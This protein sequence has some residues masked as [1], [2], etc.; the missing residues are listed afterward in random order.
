MASREEVV[1][2][3]KRNK[4]V[5]LLSQL[6]KP[7][8]IQ[9]P[10]RSIE[11]IICLLIL[12]TTLFGFTQN[13]SQ[14]F[15]VKE[16]QEDFVFMRLHMENNPNLYL[17]SSKE[18]VD[19]VFDLCYNGIVVPMTVNQFYTH[20]TSIQPVIKDGHNYLLPS[21]E[22]QNYYS[23][24]AVYLPLNYTQY[25]GKLYITQNL[26]DDTTLQVGD[27]IK[28]IN[29]EKAI[30]AYNFLISHQVRDGYNLNYSKYLAEKFFR[31][32]YVFLFGIEE[33]YH[34]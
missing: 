29:G 15:A 11:Y 5:H 8:S 30:D 23:S 2:S 16:L 31:S 34:L 14:K 17:Y 26:S 18:K 21:V 32:Y 25:E 10:M 12:Q 20:I 33:S 3:Y 4:F 7:S 13:I 24:N 6:L 19:S 27:E 28:S 1:I 22:L 9:T